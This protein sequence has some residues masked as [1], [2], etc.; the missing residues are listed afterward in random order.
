VLH[1]LITD[2]RLVALVEGVAGLRAGTVERFTG[3]VYQMVPRRDA[4]GYHNDVHHK[5]LRLMAVSLSLAREPCRGGEVWVRRRGYWR[6]FHR[7]GP[8]ALGGLTVFRIS[9][10]LQ[11]KIGRVTAGERTNLAGWYCP[12][13]GFGYAA[14]IDRPLFPA[15]SPVVE[16]AHRA[17]A[18]R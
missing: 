13:P 11:H 16:W 18:R 12:D 9:R 2:A 4:D 17:L 1:Y 14:W 6:P 15:R 3:R 10:A 5:D 8:L 7:A